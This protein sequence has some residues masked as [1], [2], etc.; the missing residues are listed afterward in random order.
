MDVY[1]TDIEAGSPEEAARI[2]ADRST[3]EADLIDDCDGESTAALVAIAG[4]N[5]YISAS[6][7]ASISTEVMTWPSACPKSRST[8]LIHGMRWEMIRS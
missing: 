7:T 5:D 4:E 6:C 3:R 8:H 1:L 2:A